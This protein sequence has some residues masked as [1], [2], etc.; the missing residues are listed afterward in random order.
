MADGNGDP[1][2]GGEDFVFAGEFALGVLEGEQLA[3]AQRRQLTDPVFADAVEWWG[4]RLGTMAEEA[5]DMLPQDSTWQAIE[6]RLDGVSGAATTADAT[7]LPIHEQPRVA[8]WSIALALGGAGLAAAAL[9]L[10][11]A[12]P[13]PAAIQPPVETATP[14]GDQLIAQLRDETGE[15]TLAGRIDAETG[16]LSLNVAGF[17]PQEGQ[18][19]VLWLIP[20]GVD[21]P[22]SLGAIPA[23]GAFARDLDQRERDLIGEG[24]TLAVTIEDDE[25]APYAAPTT[26]AVLAGQLTRV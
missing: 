11:I 18:A 12:T 19:P 6:R 24:A 10:Y 1:G 21:T 13:R 5:G 15:V 4:L 9:A 3:L 23:D 14:A 26:P 20:A 17:A 25:H 7:P 22:V 8:G 16:R 2:A